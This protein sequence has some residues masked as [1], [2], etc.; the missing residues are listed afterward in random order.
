M[1]TQTYTIEQIMAAF[2]SVKRSVDEVGGEGEADRERFLIDD[3]ATDVRN[4]LTG[5]TRSEVT[6]AN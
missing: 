3:V 6:T 2:E 5:D 1:S 4:A